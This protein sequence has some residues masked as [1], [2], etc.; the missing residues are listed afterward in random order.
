M[1]LYIIFI[2]GCTPRFENIYWAITR[3]LNTT[4][5]PQI[6]LKVYIKLINL[7]LPCLAMWFYY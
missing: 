6:Y 7:I 3:N 1:Y 5:M 4:A 2:F